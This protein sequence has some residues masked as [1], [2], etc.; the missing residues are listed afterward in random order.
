MC[1]KRFNKKKHLTIIFVYDIPNSK[2][3]LFRNI[4]LMDD[5]MMYVIINVPIELVIKC[6]MCYVKKN[7]E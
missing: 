6:L 2:M 5:V 4:M 3:V 7:T 1:Y